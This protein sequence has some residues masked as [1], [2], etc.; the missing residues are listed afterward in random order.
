MFKILKLL[1]FASFLGVF[2]SAC[3]TA[4]PDTELIIT[5]AAL[6]EEGPLSELMRTHQY[7]EPENWDG[8]VVTWAVNKLETNKSLPIKQINQYLASED[9]TYRVGVLEV[10]PDQFD[11]TT[12]WGTE[13]SERLFE[14]FDEYSIDII[15]RGYGSVGSA[16]TLL[17]W[18]VIDQQLIEPIEDL[19]NSQWSYLFE[20]DGEQWGIGSPTL[21]IYGVFISDN[22]ASDET[23]TITAF[24]SEKAQAYLD[25]VI[26]ANSGVDS[27]LFAMQAQN[28]V[29]GYHMVPDLFV[30]AN[31]EN[32]VITEWWKTNDYKNWTEW[33]NKQSSDLIVP[34]DAVPITYHQDIIFS[35][36]RSFELSEAKDYSYLTGD[37]G[38]FIP[39]AFNFVQF[40][41][42][43]LMENMLVKDTSHREEAID[44]LIRLD[45]DLEL[46][47]ILNEDTAHV[48]RQIY[49]WY[50]AP[51]KHYFNEWLLNDDLELSQQLEEV[52]LLTEISEEKSN[53]AVTLLEELKTDSLFSDLNY[54]ETVP[55]DDERLTPLNE[56]VELSGLRSYFQTVIEEGLQ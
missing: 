17:N 44:F 18:K 15:H 29:S 1:A 32:A 6:E 5:E 35:S 23:A 20:H 21:D 27:F 50:D 16:D 54:F 36:S 13:Y 11:Q 46:A 41:W 3:A 12:D 43:I 51:H 26:L 9:A 2:S 38:H 28:L 40:D 33:F 53:E 45:Q 56:K 31:D 55:A 42:Q 7:I 30:L 34:D 19:P 48:N 14:I 24:D 39:L 4:Y 25:E 22:L 10:F 52:K 47:A 49:T 37:S 8:P